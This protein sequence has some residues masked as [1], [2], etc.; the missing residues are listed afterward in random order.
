[1]AMREAAGAWKDVGR[2]VLE[3]VRRRVVKPR[4]S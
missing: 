3:E 1:M 2:E 4:G